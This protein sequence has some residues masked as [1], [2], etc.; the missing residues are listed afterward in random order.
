M[1]PYLSC[2]YSQPD[3]LLDDAGSAEKKIGTVRTQSGS[4]LFKSLLDDNAQLAFGS[5]WPVSVFVL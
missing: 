2:F 3:H 4:Y 5:D 1:K